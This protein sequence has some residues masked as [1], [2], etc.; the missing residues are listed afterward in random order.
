MRLK[1]LLALLSLLALGVAASGC[2]NSTPVDQTVTQ[3]ITVGTGT[4]QTVVQPSG[5][6][7]TTTGGGG[8]ET[9]TGGGQT[10]GGG[11]TTGGGTT[12][13]GGGGGGEPAA[14][15]LGVSSL[16]CSACHTL[17]DAGWKGNVGPNLDEAKPEYS[18][19]V[20]F[21]TNGAGGGAMPSFKSQFSAAQIKCI[22]AYVPAPAGAW[23]QA[24]TDAKGRGAPA[25]IADACKGVKLSSS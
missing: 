20:D 11:E 3:A 9:T 2:F 10:T 15:A 6:S 18:L 5:A 13:G 21:V 19:V 25:S 1:A 23:G 22:A 7:G 12:T 24:M 4:S 16:P 17:A 8:G 14:Q